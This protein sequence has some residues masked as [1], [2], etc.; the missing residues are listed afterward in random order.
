MQKG[1]QEIARTIR[2]CFLKVRNFIGNCVLIFVILFGILLVVSEDARV[3]FCDGFCSAL[4]SGKGLDVILIEKGKKKRG[5]PKP[6]S[7][8]VQATEQ[9][10]QCSLENLF[11]AENIELP[12]S[13]Q[14]KRNDETVTIDFSSLDSVDAREC[15]VRFYF[16][17][18]ISKSDSANAQTNNVK[19]LV[20]ATLLPEK[21]VLTINP[22]KVVFLDFDSVPTFIQHSL[23]LALK[24]NVFKNDI[25]IL[26]ENRKIERLQYDPVKRVYSFVYK[27]EM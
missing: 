5:I 8:Y 7:E 21:N 25:L 2:T 11:S 19:I 26:P 24:S 23:R 10:K 20:E 4:E 15:E 13:W 18:V 12:F 16:K 1:L 22:S 17:G 27:K 14:F 3:G 9:S 6:E